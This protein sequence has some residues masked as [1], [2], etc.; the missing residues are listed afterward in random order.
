MMA[1]HSLNKNDLASFEAH[2]KRAVD[3][4][5]EF[6]LPRSALQNQLHAL[7]LLLLMVENRS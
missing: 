4:Y 3:I 6:G 2:G 7:Y 1:M 5:L